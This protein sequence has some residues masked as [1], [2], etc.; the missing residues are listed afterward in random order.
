MNTETIDPIWIRAFT[1][2]IDILKIFLGAF[3][4]AA[5][6]FAYERRRKHDEE[7]NKRTIALRDAQFALVA[8]INSFLILQKQHLAPQTGNPNRWVELPPFLYVTNPPV[9]PMAEL[10]F[11]LDDVDPNL[12]GE[13]VV[14]RDK[15]NTVCEIIAYRNKKH[16][17]FQL[18][19]EKNETSEQLKVQLTQFTDA[20]YIQLPD[21]VLFMYSV[22]DKLT[23]IMLKHFKDVNALCIGGEIEQMI[24]SLQQEERTRYGKS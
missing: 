22:L 2:V 15:F 20:L 11:L 24:K 13:L 23:Q 21:A 1:I 3:C 12:L 14:A 6:A 4:G 17:E 19:S 8:R 5:F 9:F 7:R 16:D 10:S 18:L